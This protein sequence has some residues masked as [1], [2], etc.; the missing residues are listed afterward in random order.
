MNVGMAMFFQG[1]RGMSD[2]DVYRHEI[3]LG[4][5]AEPLGFQAIWSVEHHFDDYT[6]VPDVTQFLTFWAARTRHVQLG[7]EVVVLPWH[8]PIRVAEEVALL[9]QLSGGRFIFGMGRGVARSEFEG[10]GVDQEASRD[11]FIESAQMILRG[12]ETGVC[13]FDGKVV[14]QVRRQIRPRPVRSFKDRAFAAI[15]SPESAEIMARLGVGVLLIPAKP[16]AMVEADLAAYR[17][18]F[19]EIQGR[20]A[21]API[22]VSFVY[23][24]RDVARAEEMANKYMS[25]YQLSAFAHYEMTGE[26]LPKMRGY[27]S[28]KPVQQALAAPG[29]IETAVK[30][31]VKTQAW[32]TPEMCYRKLREHREIIGAQGLILVFSYGEMPYDAAERSLRLFAAEVL[33]EVKKL[34]PLEQQ[35][36]TLAATAQA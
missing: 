11:L 34:C 17:K 16:R 6:M 1:Q 14:H 33:P 18:H 36:V 20:A 4:D 5:L 13:E 21:P 25:A 26:H 23:C 22:S 29:G 9:D 10:L 7:S 32:G 3:A 15:T 30:A 31:F 19:L 24:D 28:Y 27:E 2:S 35:T 8:N 12:L